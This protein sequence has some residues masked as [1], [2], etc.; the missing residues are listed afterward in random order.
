MTT[1]YPAEP[2]DRE[3][4]LTLASDNPI[5]A[6]LRKQIAHWIEPHTVNTYTDHREA[7]ACVEIA[8]PLIRAYI[9]DRER[10]VHEDPQ[11]AA[12]I[13]EGIAQ[14]QRGETVDLGSFAQHLDEDGDD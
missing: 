3:Q 2:A 6:D 13:R 7:M 8:Y 4:A 10:L 9:A 12:Q 5:P 1:T 14:A 11:L